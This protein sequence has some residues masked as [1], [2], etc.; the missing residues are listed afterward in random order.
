MYS[1]D[2]DSDLCTCEHCGARYYPEIG[3]PGHIC[4]AGMAANQ[5][6]SAAWEKRFLAGGQRI[7]IAIV[8]ECYASEEAIS[9]AMG[10]VETNMH[11]IQ[12]GRVVRGE[13][14]ILDHKWKIKAELVR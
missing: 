10:F 1:G 7:R 11:G 6:Q 3:P 8:V 2:D 12:S 13:D 14:D 4:A 5:A 9:S